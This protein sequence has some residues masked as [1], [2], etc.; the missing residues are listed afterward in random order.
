MVSDKTVGDGKT[1][2]LF[3]S[4]EC[5]YL[6]MIKELHILSPARTF[7]G[8]KDEIKGLFNVHSGN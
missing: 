1:A 4:V 8:V 3:Y 7:E 2:N 5:E 6:S